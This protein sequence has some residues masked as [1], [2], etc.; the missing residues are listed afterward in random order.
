MEVSSHALD[1]DRVDGVR[2]HAA[3]FTNLTRDHLDY[4]GTMEAYG[5]AKARLFAWPDADARAS[6]TSMMPSAP[7]SARDRCRAAS[8][9]IVPRHSAGAAGAAGRARVRARHAGAPR[10]GGAC[11]HDGVEH[12][13]G[14]ELAAALMG[15]FN[16]EN[17]LM[18]LAVLLSWDV[19][20]AEA[21]QRA[22][23]VRAAPRTHGGGRRPRPDRRWPGRLRAH[24][25]C[26][27]QGAAGGA[28]SIARGALWCVFGCGGDRDRGK[29]PLMGRIA[30]E[31]ADEIIV[32]DD[33]PRSEDPRAHRRAISSPASRRGARAHHRSRSRARHPRRTA[34]PAP[35]D[36]VLI[37][38]KGHEDYQIIA[39]ERRAFSDR[40]RCAASSRGCRHEAHPGRI[41]A[42][43]SAGSSGEDRRLQRRGDR[44]PHAQ[45]A[46]RCSWRCAGRTSTAGS[47]LPPR[48]A[49]G[50]AGAVGRTAAPR[51]CRRSSCRTP[52]RR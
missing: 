22:G 16:A 18:V 12:F 3:A 26:A 25:R 21:A 13:G 49:A 4:H 7:R 52:W 48:P 47:S 15:G 37:A 31:L 32:T 27:R 44:Q 2:F 23:R 19:P 35:D 11:R 20:L 38:G 14:V 28:R 34:A 17:A 10:V 45:A 33:N 51:R 9:L 29:R 1:Q 6:S 30:D 50:A 39:G 8:P 36:V 41:R 24:A 40:P 43:L 46:A 42:R 5:A